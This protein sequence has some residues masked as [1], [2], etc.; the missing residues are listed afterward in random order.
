[1]PGFFDLFGIAHK[2]GRD[3]TWSDNAESQSVAILSG[4]LASNYSPQ[5]TQLAAVLACHPGPR[6]PM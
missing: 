4:A 5:V 3:F 2:N 1:V 6:E